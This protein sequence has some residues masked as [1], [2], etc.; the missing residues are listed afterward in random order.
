LSKIG[1]HQYS[2]DFYSELDSAFDNWAEYA[3]NKIKEF[4]GK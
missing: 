4:E 2:E 3:V 1:Y